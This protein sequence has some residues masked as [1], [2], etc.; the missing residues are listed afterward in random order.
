MK[1]TF[2]SAAA[3]ILTATTLASAADVAT[4]IY[5]KAPPVLPSWWDK[6]TITGHVEAGATF[7]ADGTAG[8]NFGH[9]FTDKADHS[10]GTKIGRSSGMAWW[11]S[12]NARRKQS[13]FNG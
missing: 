13:K 2:L 7:K 9:L 11:M 12:R 6:L 5:K 8:A 1:R 10:A 4:P 3:I